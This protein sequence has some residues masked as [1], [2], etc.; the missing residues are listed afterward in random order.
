MLTEM[1]KYQD[2]YRQA[3]E[4]QTKKDVETNPK[5]AGMVNNKKSQK[6]INDRLKA[7]QNGKTGGRPKLALTKD[8]KMLNKLLKKEL[9]LKDAADIMGLTM[10][11]LSQIK[12]RYNLPRHEPN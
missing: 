12:S 7:Q 11:S 5:L 2:L 8:A 3:W 4:A 6:Q 10:Q 9:S 1:E